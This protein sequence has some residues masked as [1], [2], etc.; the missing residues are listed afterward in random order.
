M[1]RSEQHKIVQDLKYY[2][3]SMSG[4][5]RYE[6]DMI[7]KRDKDDEDLDARARQTLERLATLYLPKKSKKDV[8]D[9]WKKLTSG[10]PASGS[11]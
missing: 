9:L 2:N 6:F 7:L 1:T 10:K 3:G 8:E 11:Q 4:T 5:D